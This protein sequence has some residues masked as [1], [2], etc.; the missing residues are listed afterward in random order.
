M[1]TQ[2][3]Y[4]RILP[5]LM[6]FMIVPFISFAQKERSEIRK[7]NEYYEKNNFKMAE[8]AYAKAGA[9]NKESFEAQFNL[10]NSMYKQGK[11]SE[12]S[13]LFEKLLNRTSDRIQKSMVY[14]NLGNVLLKS[15]LVHES[16]EAYKNAL[17]NNPED[18]AA[19]YNLS[20]ALALLS[21]SPL[22]QQA[23][24]EDSREILKIIEQE[25]EAVK[26]KM[27]EAKT[28]VPK[29]KKDW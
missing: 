4:Y 7:G 28:S 27:R 18:S 16:I 20:Y 19:R 10:A 25:E 6:V 5:F 9:I 3:Y 11:L 14:H 29:V 1:I 17:K 15:E 13:I 21:D 22:D 8:E 23:T 24:P 2:L 26:R 12:A